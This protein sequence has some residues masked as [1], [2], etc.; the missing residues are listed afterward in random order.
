MDQQE[1][2]I[3]KEDIRDRKSL[4][5]LKLVTYEDF[6]KNTKQRTDKVQTEDKME[7]TENECEVLG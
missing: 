4:K 7:N 2:E 5:R 6:Q 1:V 3:T